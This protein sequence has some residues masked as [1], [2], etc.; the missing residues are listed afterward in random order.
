MKHIPLFWLSLLLTLSST[1]QSAFDHAAVMT[2]TFHA[3][4]YNTM[5]SPLPQPADHSLKTI[6]RKLRR[7]RNYIISGSVLMGVGGA[8]FLA[9]T[10]YAI[11]Q[12]E[13]PVRPGP[14]SGNPTAIIIWI[15]AIPEIALGV[16]LLSV[17]VVQQHKWRTIKSEV[18]IHA[19]LMNNGNMGLVMNF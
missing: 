3:N 1:G 18:S 8:I 15:M 6:D 10:G 17:G 12:V 13:Q 4:G 11:W 5:F 7:S 2:T 19:G 14:K 9:G 16:P